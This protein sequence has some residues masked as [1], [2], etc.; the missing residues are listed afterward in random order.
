VEDL[1]LPFGIVP[2]HI[3]SQWAGGWPDHTERVFD[4]KVLPL[5]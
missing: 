5:P 3:H 1:Q 4:V 2:G